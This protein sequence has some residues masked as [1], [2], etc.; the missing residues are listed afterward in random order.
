MEWTT[1]PAPLRLK[2]SY[3][4]VTDFKTLEQSCSRPQRIKEAAE[5]ESRDEHQN[6]ELHHHSAKR[7]DHEI[8]L[9]RNKRQPVDTV[10]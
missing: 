8:I 6:D 10:S 4:L 2:L 7:E 9:Q 3:L 1:N 5:A